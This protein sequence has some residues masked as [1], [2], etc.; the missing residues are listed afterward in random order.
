MPPAHH[1][2]ITVADLDRAVEFY[3]EVFDLDTLTEFSVGGEGLSTAVDVPDAEAEFVHL[4]GDGV[5]IEL[6]EYDPEGEDRTGAAVNDPGGAH[7]GFSVDDVDGFYDDLPADVETLSEPQTS[8]TGTRILFLR[9][10]E[11]N[12]IEVL[13]A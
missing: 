3:S 1:V 5:R 6:V 12:L 4:D 9:D 8:S 11:G 7:L 2:G 10:P 13:D